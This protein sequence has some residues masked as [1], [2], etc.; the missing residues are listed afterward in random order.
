MLWGSLVGIL[1][2]YYGIMPEN[3]VRIVAL[4]ELSLTARSARQYIPVF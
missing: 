1:Q 3:N 2:E 4:V